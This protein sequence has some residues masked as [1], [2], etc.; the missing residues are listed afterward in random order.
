MSDISLLQQAGAQPTRPTKFAPLAV[1]TQFTGMW[2]NRNPLIQPGSRSDQRFYGGHPDV[3]IDGLNVEITS[4]NTLCRRPGYSQWSTATLLSAATSFY[5]WEE[6]NE[7]LAIFADT[8]TAVYSVT[9]T[10]ATSVFTKSSGAGQTTFQSVGASLYMGNGVDA[11]RY[12]STS[13]YIHPWGIANPNLTQCDITIG[14]GSLT[15]TSTTGWSYVFCYATEPPGASGYFHCSSA[16]NP[17]INTLAHSNMSVQVSGPGVTDGISNYVLIFRTTDGESTYLYDGY[18]PNPGAGQTWYFNDSATDRDLNFELTA[19]TD[20]TNNPP[21]TGLTNLT[22][23]CGRVWGSVGNYIYYATGPDCTCGDGNSAWAPLNYFQ[24]TSTVTKLVPYA[25][26]LLVFTVDNLHVIRGTCSA[27]GAALTGG[28]A[29]FIAPYKP[30]IGVLS[31]NA[32][33]SYGSYIFAFTSDRRLLCFNPGAGVEDLGFPVADQWDG[34]NPANVSVA[35]HAFGRK[36]KAIFVCDGSGNVWRCDPSQLPESTAC[37]SP[38]AVVAAGIS[39]IQ[40]VETTLGQKQLLASSGTNILFRDWTSFTDAGTPYSAY[41]TWGSL[42]LAEPGQLAEVEHLVVESMAVGS[43]PSVWVLPQELGT[44]T[45]LNGTS[46]TAP[47]FAQLFQAVNDPPQLM[48]S[49]TVYSKRY[50][51]AQSGLPS[52]MRHLQFKISLPPENQPNEVLGYSI[53]GS[54]KPEG[55]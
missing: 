46:L 49:S 41:A 17:S 21:P 5:A 12:D 44:P 24:V 48:P 16:S 30:G 18:V 43:V 29:F 15:T 4:R 52:V 1:R 8:S 42:V 23:W 19:P 6:L 45:L 39:L 36:D 37:W 14:T 50:H 55:A 20:S 22:Y 27:T 13:P 54:L 11:K 10:S 40:S 51:W 53:Y 38:K 35:F 31:Y 34:V 3:L 33:D 9:P 32:I 25:N 26:G 47:S 7:S 2:T 28:T